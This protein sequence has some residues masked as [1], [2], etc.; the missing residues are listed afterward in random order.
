MAAVDLSRF[1][2]VSFAAMTPPAGTPGDTAAGAG[3]GAIAPARAAAESTCVLLVFAK[4]LGR[5]GAVQSF[6]AGPEWR[7]ITVTFADLG[8]DAT[9][10]Q[11]LFFGGGPTPGPL[12]LQ[13]DDVRLVPKP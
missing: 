5:L 3:A 6:A 9:D 13:I 7:R 4:H 11:A 2:G 1:S 12:R 10:L 8:L